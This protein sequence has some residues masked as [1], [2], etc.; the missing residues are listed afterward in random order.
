MGTDV[1]GLSRFL[2]LAFAWSWGMW[3]AIPSFDLD[4]GLAEGLRIAG[5][6]GPS[7][8][9]VVVA[10]AD[11]GRDGL[12]RLLVPLTRWRAPSRLWLTAILGPPAVVLVAIALAASLGQPPG[13]FNDPRTAYLI[14]PAFI[15]ILIIG[16]PLG[17]EIG[18]RGFALDR[19]QVRLG[20]PAASL[21]LGLTWGLWHLPLFL[22]PD[23]VQY[24]LPLATYL[25]QTTA[26]AFVY[27]WL[28]NR[29]RSLPVVLTLHTA[30]N[31]AAGVFPLLV[32]EAPSHAP[33]TIAVGLAAMI[34]IGLTWGTRS[35]L[36]LA[37]PRCR[38][39]SGPGGRP[40]ASRPAPITAGF[41]GVA[42]GPGTRRW[43]RGTRPGTRPS[44]GGR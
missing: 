20:P 41:T 42:G 26:T 2:A 43:P 13:P 1:R 10:T 37:R 33:I 40:A 23:E 22:N 30:T 19:L 8:A 44:R 5:C 31:V 35:R 29:T 38:A 25:G 18:W 11:G 32:P 12:R 6:F 17:E 4:G 9:A 36:D 21:L 28:W 27:T 16:G 15:T 14:V 7:L 24:A 34:A 39:G 3:L